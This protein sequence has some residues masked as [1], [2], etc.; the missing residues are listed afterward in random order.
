M[1]AFNGAA[2]PILSHRAV[3]FFTN[4]GKVQTFDLNEGRL[5]TACA[6]DYRFEYCAARTVESYGDEGDVVI[7]ASVSSALLNIVK[8]AEHAQASGIKIGAVAGKKSR[9]PLAAFSDIGFRINS[10]AY[11][12]VEA[13]DHRGGHGCGPRRVSVS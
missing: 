5:I 10:R 12:V 9:Q 7:S 1:L 6:N 13:V 4:P 8:C 3:I 11:N 2:T